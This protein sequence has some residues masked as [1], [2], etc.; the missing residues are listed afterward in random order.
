[1]DGKGGRTVCFGMIGAGGIAKS[2]HLPN[3][4]R[5]PHVRLKTIC[6]LDPA[7]LESAR[8]AYGIPHAVADAAELL[9]DPEISAVIVATREDAQAPL[10]IAALKAGKH[11]YV[12]KPVA[13][14]AEAFRAVIAARDASGKHVAVGFNRRFAPAYRKAAEVLMACGGPRNIYYR[15]ADNYTRG[16]GRDYPPGSRLYHEVCHVFD[17]LRWLTGSEAESVYCVNSRPDDEMLVIRFGSGCVAAVMN[18]GYG[19][20]DLP[21]ERLEAVGETGG[22]AVEEFVE[23]RTFGRKEFD[24]VYRFAGHS[25]PD[26]DA[27]HVEAFRTA[28][29][30]ALYALR[31]RAFEEGPDSVPHLNY[32]VDKGWIASLDGFAAAILEGRTPEN[33]GPRDAFAAHL[34]ADA[35]GKSRESGRP[36]SPDGM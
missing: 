23:V 36:V 2:Q 14:T 11:V 12:E 35:A 28:G 24:P 13:V 9:A 25:H 30:E 20:P 32:R 5:A 19:T 16:W 1:M 31:R 18:S 6:D 27:G 10:T 33:A 4:P 22:V 21:K 7:A 3:I 29:A 15:I 17:V 34:L 8:S 26:H